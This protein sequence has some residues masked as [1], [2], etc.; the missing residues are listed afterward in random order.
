[1]NK[2]KFYILIIVFLLVSNLLLV[3]FMVFRRPPNAGGDHPKFVIIERLHFD[4]K[5]I[6]QFEELI[7]IH[8]ANIEERSEEIKKA[9]N[10]LYSGLSGSSNMEKTDSLFHVIAKTQAE[11]EKIHFNHFKE[12]QSI[13]HPN[14]LEDYKELTGEIAQ[15]FGRNHQ[16][17][18]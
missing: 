15:L 17:P 2:N 3:G 14:Q 5:Q 12:I 7:K 4:K 1:M 9:K 13:C 10:E 11:I 16:R 8:R 6:Y 18:R